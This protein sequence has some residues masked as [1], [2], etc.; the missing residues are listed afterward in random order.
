MNIWPT[1][2]ILGGFMTYRGSNIKYFKIFFFHPQGT[3]CI[4]TEHGRT[5]NKILEGRSL[6]ARC[7]VTPHPLSPIFF[8]NSEPNYAAR[9]W[10]DFSPPPCM[11][12]SL[13]NPQLHQSNLELVRKLLNLS[14][15]DCQRSFPK[16]KTSFCLMCQP[17][18]KF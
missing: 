15:L 18:S 16:H 8:T 5:G 10:R 3:G 4:I 11:P 14:C 9:I 13:K 7:L 6:F 1:P 2:G 12:I 17:H